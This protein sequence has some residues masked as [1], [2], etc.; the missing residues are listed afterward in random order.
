MP[1][2]YLEILTTGDVTPCCA[3]YYLYGN[4]KEK[5]I[6]EIWNDDPIKKLRLD[7]FS[8][9]L[10]EACHTCREIEETGSEC[11]LRIIN[12]DK[13]K[14]TFDDIEQITNPDGSISQL[15][16]RGW[17]FKLKNKCN[18]KCRTCTPWESELI[19]K[20]NK[21]IV[22]HKSNLSSVKGSFDTDDV[23]TLENTCQSV[24]D[25]FDFRQF[26]LD[27]IDNLE[28]I[29]FAGGETLIMDE[30]YELLDILLKN[31]KTDIH[32]SYNTNMSIM[33][34]KSYHILDYWRKWNPDKLTVIASIDEIGERAEHI[35]KGTV[36]KVVE[37]NLKT[38]VSEGFNRRTNDVIGCHN[39]FRLPE[40]ITYLTE[41]DYISPKFD[42]L[43]FD[44]SVEISNYDLRALSDEFKSDIIIK[45]NNFIEI[46]NKKYNTDISAK[47]IHVIETLKEPHHIKYAMRYFKETIKR[48]KFRNENTFEVIPEMKDI[49]K[50]IK[51]YLKENSVK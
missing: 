25:D 18:F 39:V 34:Y 36:W 3:S 11:S 29:E 27:Q 30:H 13:F 15:K 28:M 44:L 21:E 22:D 45:L 17:D 19:A 23:P 41:I 5:S 32:L 4:V 48:D 37:K 35:R 10:P 40:I 49:K 31:N 20:E 2:T 26:A 6:E 7:M 51:K 47:F 9:K 38:I 43:N 16:F 42:C 33:K 46:Y 1:W 12:N 50:S 14:S 8:D 24:T